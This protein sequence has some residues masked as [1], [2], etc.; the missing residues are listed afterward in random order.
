ML[1]QPAPD[2]LIARG[3]TIKAVTPDLDCNAI[4]IAIT[5]PTFKRPAQII[6]TIKSL[7]N[8]NCTK[9]TAIIVMDND[10]IDQEGIAATQA[11]F[12]TSAV[13]GMVVLVSDAGNCNA[14]NGGWL[15][16]LRL[17]PHLNY[18][19]VIDD[20]ERADPDWLQ[21]LI[22]TAETTK[23]DI[24]GGPQL[25]VFPATSSQ[26]HH[27]HPIFKPAYNVTGPVPILYSSGN[28]LIGRHVFDLMAKPFLDDAF[29]FT[30]GGDADFY[31]RAKAKDFQFAWCAEA[32]VRE[33]VPERRLQADWLRARSLRNGALSAIVERRKYQHQRLGRIRTFTHSTILFLAAPIRAVIDLLK[34]GSTDKALDRLYVGIGRMQGEFGYSNEQYRQPQNN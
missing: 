1:K 12:E 15:T 16:A 2:Q 18:I 25:P 24:V 26:K 9:R 7:Q 8:Q 22:K 17:F 32:I 34:T 19:A 27:D 20:D 33:D 29:N 31:T 21:Q 28:V 3:V 5:V 10:V 6:E 30:G 13:I 4:E 23:A 14:Y 11:L